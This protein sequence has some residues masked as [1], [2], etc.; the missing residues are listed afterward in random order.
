MTYEPQ[1]LLPGI[2]FWFDY[3]Y[4]PTPGSREWKMDDAKHWRSDS[5]M[6]RT[7]HLATMAAT[8]G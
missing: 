7:S 1:K 5:G 2:A 4:P 3:R 6:S 8:Q